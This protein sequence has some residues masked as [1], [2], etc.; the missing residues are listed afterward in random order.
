MESDA[1]P[2]SIDQCP[3]LSAL[4]PS[5]VLGISFQVHCNRNVHCDRLAM[6]GQ[7]AQT[8]EVLTHQVH[9]YLSMVMQEVDRSEQ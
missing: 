3:W 8:Q 4:L 7:C 9:D 1:V 5:I 2:C 6:T